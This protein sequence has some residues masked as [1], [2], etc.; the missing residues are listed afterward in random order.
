MR[1]NTNALTLTSTAD[2]EPV[3]ILH[4]V[5]IVAA[6]LLQRW[7]D[8]RTERARR[9]ALAQLDAATLRDLGLDTSTV[10]GGNSYWPASR[11]TAR[12]SLDRY[13]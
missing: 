13:L 6:A 10:D 7:R 2:R 1:S 12:H 8:A 5:R 4:R 11:W 9:S 3:S